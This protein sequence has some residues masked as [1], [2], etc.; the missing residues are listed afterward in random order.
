[1]RGDDGL[2]RLKDGATAQADPAV[3]VAGG[4]LEGSNVNPVDADGDMISW[5]APSKPK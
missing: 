1:V 5:R 4:A 3:T 2:F